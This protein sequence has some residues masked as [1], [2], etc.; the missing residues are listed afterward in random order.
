[1]KHAT[2]DGQPVVYD[3]PPRRGDRFYVYIDL[4]E[5]PI[6]SFDV[7]HTPHRFGDRL[8]FTDTNGEEHTLCEKDD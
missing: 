7:A 3:E 6:L 8:V 4:I 2:L 1:M 5:G